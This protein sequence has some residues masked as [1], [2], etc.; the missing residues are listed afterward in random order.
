MENG[1]RRVEPEVDVLSEGFKTKDG[2]V[3]VAAGNDHQ[4]VAVCKVLNLSELAEN[5][6]YKTNTLRVQHR[7][8]LLQ[9]LAERFLQ[10][11]TAKWLRC[12][13]GT[14]VPCGPI[15]TIQQVFSDPQI[16]TTPAQGRVHGANSVAVKAAHDTRQTCSPAFQFI[17]SKGTT[18]YGRN[19]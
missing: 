15:N 16:H 2:Y 5:P 9:L 1:G 7:K 19:L 17:K 10:E 18:A 8:E 6:K 4:F 3:I 14:G 11:S 12:F 13:E